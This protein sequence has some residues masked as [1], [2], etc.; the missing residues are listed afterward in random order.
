MIWNYHD[1]DIK[2]E[3]EG[4]TV[5]LKGLPNKQILLQ[6]YRIDSE[7]SNSYEVW[8]KMGSPQNPTAEQIRELEKAGQLQLLGSPAYIKNANGA[9]TV[10]LNL[11]RQAVTLLKLEW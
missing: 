3:D 10:K 8:K 11:P 1:D 4:V 7:H 6:Q 9:A 5:Q 2:G